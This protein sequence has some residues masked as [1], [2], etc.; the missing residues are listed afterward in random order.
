MATVHDRRRA[1]L[2]RVAEHHSLELS[3]IST[4]LW[5]KSAGQLEL[6][7]QAWLEI[8]DDAAAGTLTDGLELCNFDH[9]EPGWRPRAWHLWGGPSD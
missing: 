1:K 5:P 3:G 7:R 4:I 9:A 8:A 6:L 2:R